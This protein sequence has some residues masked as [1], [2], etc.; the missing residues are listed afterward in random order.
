M[1]DENDIV[2]Q[3]LV[4]HDDGRVSIKYYNFGSYISDR[5]SRPVIQRRFRVSP[6]VADYLLSSIRVYLNL[7]GSEIPMAMDSGS[8][9]LKLLDDTGKRTEFSGALI[10]GI[11]LDGQSI[12]TRFR[13]YLEIDDLFVFDGGPRKPVEV[14]DGEYIFVDVVFD[15][16]DKTYCYISDVPDIAQGDEVLVPVGDDGRTVVAYVVDI[17]VETAEEAPFPVDL[18]KHIIKV[19]RE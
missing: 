3:K 16:G 17:D 14:S 2:S 8:W 19:I 4:I 18:C 12:S 7:K 13:K 10:G 5:P 11:E 1:P 9:D 6:D 15:D